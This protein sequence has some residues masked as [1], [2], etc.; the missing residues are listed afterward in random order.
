MEYRRLPHGTEQLGVLGIG[1]GG[2][3]NSSEE[4]IQKVVELA[5]D[6]GVNFLDLCAGHAKVYGAVGRAIAGK[7][8]KIYFQLHLGAVYDE[9]GTYGWSRDC[10]RIRKTFDWELEQL[11]TD[12]ADF[13]F[14]HCVDEMKDLD[15]LVDSGVWALLQELK[16]QGR[17]RHLGFSSHTPAVAQA[18]LDLGGMDMMMFSLNPAYDME[19][20]DEY[21]IGSTWERK[22][23]LE[24]C[25]VDGVGISVM[26]P[27]HGGKLLDGTRSPFGR[28]LMIPQCLQYALDRPGV[29]T[30]VPGVRN[31]EDMEKLLAFLSADQQERDYGVL[32]T[33]AP[34]AAMGSCVYCNHCMP[35]PVGIPIG[36]ANQ[37][38]DLAK[39]G[40]VLARDHYRKL[41]VKAEA[42]IGCGHC[43]SRCPFGVNQSQ[44]MKEIARYFSEDVTTQE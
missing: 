2:I 3:Q 26:K 15:Q 30:V 31:L 38:F 35:C 34:A 10:E 4:E 23:L 43:D 5:I 28:P 27:F 19:Q 11:G 32:G 18:L 9:E 36:L 14:L 22:A 41:S 42:C 1:L 7:R 13:G 6:N 21:G 39:C 37:Y 44:R 40:D 25:A 16:R 17:V 29:L 33:F 20:G 12:Y 8:G 24:R